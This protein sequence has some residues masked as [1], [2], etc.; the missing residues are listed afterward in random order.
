M[1]LRGLHQRGLL[2]VE[3][4]RVIF[5]GRVLMRATVTPTRRLRAA[6]YIP[7]SSLERT[8]VR[9]HGWLSLSLSLFL[10]LSL[11]LSFSLS[12]SLSF[13]LLPHAFC[14]LLQQLL[15]NQVTFDGLEQ[16]QQIDKSRK[17]AFKF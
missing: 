2:I 8:W 9:K 4:S 10:S 17:K 3:E 15:S 11:S 13:S 7:P 12:L 1:Q 14:T 5:S 6:L 16:K